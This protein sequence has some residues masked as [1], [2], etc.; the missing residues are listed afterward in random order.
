MP[1]SDLERLAR[2]LAAPI[3]W[4]PPLMAFGAAVT[5]GEAFGPI[6]VVG[7]IPFGLVLGAG[8]GVGW[9]WLVHVRGDD[10]EEQF[11]ERTLEEARRRP[12]P[13]GRRPEVAPIPLDPLADQADQAHDSRDA[14]AV[15]VRARLLLS[16]GRS[17]EACLEA[18][19]AIQMATLQGDMDVA[20]EVWEQFEPHRDRLVLEPSTA[21][22]LAREVDQRRRG[23]S[24]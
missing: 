16:E 1:T 13:P 2:R 6:G 8:L 5:F 12:S 7:G 14:R 21:E 15:A 10:R 17:G 4:L 18:A 19:E 9:H 3:F 20:V 23:R 11:A 24:G 22:R